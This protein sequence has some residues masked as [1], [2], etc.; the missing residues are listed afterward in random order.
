MTATE[1]RPERDAPPRRNPAIRLPGSFILTDHGVDYCSR[2]MIPMRQFTTYDRHREYGFLWEMFKASFVQK[3]VVNGFL[4]GMDVVG[5]DLVGLRTQIIDTT[6]LVFYGLLYRRFRPILN[7]IL[8]RSDA[9]QQF[10]RANP[11]ARIDEDLRFP[12]E[13]VKAFMETNG[14]A[15]RALK[16]G[17]L[18]DPF[19]EISADANLDDKQK[20][21]QKLVA[22]T[23]ID[24]IEGNTWFLF[25]YLSKS[26]DKFALGRDI[27]GVLTSFVRKAAIVDYT[28][29]MVMELIQ[30][31]EKEH[32]L[33]LAARDNMSR[34]PNADVTRLLR[35]S[36]FRERLKRNAKSQNS[37]L[38][39]NLRFGGDTTA[40]G[41][42]IRFVITVAHRG[43][44]RE[45]RR[46]RLQ[47]QAH[48]DIRYRP[49]SDLYQDKDAGA[50]SS[51][52]GL[53]YLSYLE[54]VCR[55]EDIKFET[56]ILSDDVL[57]QTMSRVIFSI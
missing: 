51:G 40:S 18:F 39:L 12:P 37:L 54:E 9:V 27:G 4:K 34:G 2:R 15:V 21:E 23:M 7:G 41:E 5:T 14:K 16:A 28:A 29:F 35:D 52:L 32:Y 1:S 42:R 8:F 56:R 49:L 3:L 47:E 36:D 6:K 19:S 26:A 13:K 55:K 53:F 11:R 46:K 57:E 24:Q 31:A 22:R 17:L 45:S 44:I 30:H 10:N 33:N 48:A 50:E 43:R 20:Q 25:H 38:N